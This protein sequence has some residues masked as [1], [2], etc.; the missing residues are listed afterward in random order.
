M[1][2]RIF[3]A[4]VENMRRGV[5]DH[6]IPEDGD[7]DLS[8]FMAGLVKIGF[9]GQAALD[10]YGYDY[11]AVAANSVSFLRDS[12]RTVEPDSHLR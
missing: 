2:S 10:L 8:E 12:L 7:M 6:R 9:D 11:E 1:G 5:H 4:H 3:H